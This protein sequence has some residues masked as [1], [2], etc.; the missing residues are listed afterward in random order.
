MEINLG[1]ERI[2]ELRATYSP[3]QIREK[4]LA[5]RVEAFGQIAKLFQRPK[6][7]DIEIVLRA[8]PKTSRSR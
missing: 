6:P 4:A 2:V 3:E 8:Y 7:E 1:D 5:K